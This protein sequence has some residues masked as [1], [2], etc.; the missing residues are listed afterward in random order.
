MSE[1]LEYSGEQINVKIL[2]LSF[3]QN[4][5]ASKITGYTVSRIEI[6]IKHILLSLEKSPSEASMLKEF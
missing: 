6:S 3:S 5:H 4:F 2:I 1:C